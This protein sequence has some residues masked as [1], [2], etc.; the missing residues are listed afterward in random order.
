M[1]LVVRTRTDPSAMIDTLRRRLAQTHPEVAV[2]ATTMQENI[3]QTERADTFRTLLFGSFAGVS[4]LLAALGMYGVTA[5][6]VS[7]RR[8]EFGLRMAV[9]ATRGQVLSLV[10]RSSVAVAMLGIAAGVGLSVALTR[11]L[12]SV[13]GKLTGFDAP[14][15]IIAAIAVLLIAMLATLIPARRAASID[16]VNA[17]RTE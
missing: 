13:A 7:Q 1:Q 9:G 2:K 16:P 11:L 17:L 4:I 8:F 12:G 5:Y 3:R 10:L 15:Y 14:A 6:T